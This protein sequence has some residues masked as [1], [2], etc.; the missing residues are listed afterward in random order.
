MSVVS[1]SA[2]YIPAT[3]QARL[4]PWFPEGDSL[5]R[6]AAAGSCLVFG[7]LAGLSYFYDAHVL[8]TLLGVLA[9]ASGGARASIEAFQAMR[10]GKADINLLMV[11]AALVAA[12]LGQWD[13]GLI[14]LFLFCL[15]DALEHDALSRTRRSVH[16]LMRLRPET[17][18]LL[19]DG[20]ETAVPISALA[21][22]DVLRVRPGERFPIDGEVLEGASSAD[23]AVITGEP[24]PVEKSPGD[25]VFA[26]TIN[27]NGSLLVRMA[28]PASESTIAR[29]VR[30]VE[31]AQENRIPVQRLIDRFQSPYVLGVLAVS[32]L[33]A[34]IGALLTWDWSSSVK[35]AM[36]LLVAASPCALVIASPVAILAAVTRG[37][38][39]GVL[40]KGGAHI[41]QLASV[42]TVGV[43]KTGTLTLGKPVLSEIEV[44]PGADA[45]RVL[46]VAAAVE[47]H[48]THPL[49]AAVVAGANARKLSLPE[50]T[51]VVNQPG[52]GLW[53][54]V[55]GLRT[56]VGSRAL[57]ESRQVSL[58]ATLQSL[59]G[60][61]TGQTK[62][63]VLR[64]DGLAG[65]LCVRD[66]ARPEAQHAV[67]L[68]KRIGIQ[69]ILILTG[70]HDA[71]A[72]RVALQLGIDDVRADL[73]PEDKLMEIRRLAKLT[74]VAMVGDG[75]NDAPA[76][77]AATVGVAMGAAG[78]DVAL[79]T[80]DVV[81][82]RDDLRLLPQA[83]HLARRCRSVVYQSLAF[84]AGVALLLI[85]GTLAGWMSL[86]VAVVCHEG[87]TLLVALNGLRLLRE[88]PLAN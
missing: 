65:V 4:G 16:A 56:G 83:I 12:A 75:V 39:Q 78:S 41:E 33:T 71:A 79:E 87:S 69:Q 58:P 82:M 11:L 21:V 81:L 30:M 40:F 27:N 35:T 28:R 14:L 64:S 25:A 8:T 32:L 60:N 50:A 5:P 46:A 26:G 1:S 10:A 49:A 42:T 85:A 59:L 52:L 80:A 55:E 77:A 17:A 86:P 51:D 70:D 31:S 15:S 20:V 23:E 53:A 48:S 73:K 7:L 44:P 24:L 67:Q 61:N 76:L 13:E 88:P 36:V 3:W 72:R 54:Q 29:I 68:L 57:F 2:W 74:P 9:F 66:Q 84:A 38:R 6:F 63:I 47:K 37:A 18:T 34:L 45:N 19:R 43:D 62:M 22:G